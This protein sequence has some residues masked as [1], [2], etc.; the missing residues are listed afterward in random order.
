MSRRMK[1]KE[2]FKY[3]IVILV[4]LAC[5]AIYNAFAAQPSIVGITKGGSNGV[6]DTYVIKY[7]NGKSD[8]ITIKNG[9]NGKDVTVNDLYI[10]TKTALNKGDDY[11]LLD[12]INDYMNYTVQERDE[13]KAYIGALSTVEVYC[14]FP[15]TKNLL[16]GVYG[17]KA[18]AGGG[19]IYQQQGDDENFYILTNY[20]V[21]YNR[22]SLTTDRIT[23][24]ITCF[25][26]G[27]NVE[28]TQTATSNNG[29]TYSYG[30]DGF[31]CTYI[32][33]S[34]ENDIAVLKVD[35][36]EVI[37]SSSARAVTISQVD[38]VIGETIVAIGNPQG[39]GTSV[40]KGIVSVDSEYMSMTAC[41]NITKIQFRVIRID[42]SINGGN[43]GGGLYNT[44]GEL[45]GIV[46]SKLQ[47]TEIEGMAFALPVSNCIRVADNIINN[48]T[49]YATKP[50]LGLKTKTNSSK[51]VYNAETN[52]IRI[53]ETIEIDS[54]TEGS[55]CDGKLFAGDIINSVTVSGKTYE[56]DR[57]FRLKELVWLMQKDSV[58]IFNVTRLSNSEV[59]N[60]VINED[61][62]QMVE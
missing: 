61:C 38:P 53:V 31:N 33:G 22:E 44:N 11:T 10:A 18:S 7:S 25:L 19:V 2:F 32:G 17:Y 13:A 26:Y 9:E 51:A 37:K 46:N 29:Y 34:M 58:V 27:A 24:K 8:S 40:T 30:Q 16:T 48:S 59:V 55:I 43:S 56:I 6:Y 15:T 39:L 21:V 45:I 49:I 3:V 20:H 62:F 1:L 60:I 23:T 54:V 14:E 4:C 41:D 36:P 5:T 52:A 42:A 47:A 28:I 50:V 57:D 12:F 35:T